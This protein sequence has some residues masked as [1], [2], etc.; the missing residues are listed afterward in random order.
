MVSFRTTPAENKSAGTGPDRSPPGVHDGRVRRNTD[1]ERLYEI[2][3]RRKQLRAGSPAGR[4]ASRKLVSVKNTPNG[5]PPKSW[6]TPD[7]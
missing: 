6:D 4:E 2:L 3:S 7:T 5:R 1:M